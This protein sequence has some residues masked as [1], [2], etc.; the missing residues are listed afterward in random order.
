LD[1]VA[2]CD[3]VELLQQQDDDVKLQHGV[4][5]PVVV[6]PWSG[7][8]ARRRRRSGLP[9]GG[10]GATRLRTHRPSGSAGHSGGGGEP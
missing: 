9:A 7:R 3:R 5:E 2:Q 8:R 10:D 6:S 4:T 1:G